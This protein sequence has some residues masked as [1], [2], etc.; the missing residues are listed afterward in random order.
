MIR[1]LNLTIKESSC[2]ELSVSRYELRNSLEQ[3]ITKV[4]L[5]TD[6]TKLVF[7]ETLLYFSRFKISSYG[8]DSFQK[9]L[10]SPNVPDYVVSEIQG[11]LPSLYRQQ[12]L[13]KLNS[14]GEQ[15]PINEKLKTFLEFQEYVN[16]LDGVGFEKFIQD[17]LKN[18][19]DSIEMTKATGDFG[20]DLIGQFDSKKV[21]IQAKRYADSV[22]LSAIQEVFAGAVYHNCNESW[23]ITSS[24]FTQAAIELAN[25]LNVRTYDGQAVYLMYLTSQKHLK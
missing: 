17:I 14:T 20:V 12:S 11:A 7:E 4:E 6:I 10:I 16:K 5:K 25:K 23:V 24:K 19:F 21:A 22:S 13:S 9:L 8:L 15:V 2:W 18:T 1:Y 3:L